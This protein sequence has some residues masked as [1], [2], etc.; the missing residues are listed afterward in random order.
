VPEWVLDLLLRG[1][2]LLEWFAILIARLGVGLMFAISGW[3]KLR[4]P[5]RHRQMVETMGRASIPCPWLAG[6]LVATTEV[7]AGTLLVV[8]LL[9]TLAAAALLVVTTVAIATV[10]IDEVD[11]KRPSNWLEN[12]LYMPEALYVIIL[13]WL[14]T[15]GPGIVSLD[16]LLWRAAS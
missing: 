14:I 13:A 16:Y 2:E 3:H 11:G 8:G 15:S 12:F 1:V 4:N 10:T 5:E 6:P 9:T 7:T